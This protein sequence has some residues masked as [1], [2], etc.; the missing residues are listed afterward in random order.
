MIPILATLAPLAQAGGVRGGRGSLTEFFLWLGLAI[1]AIVAAGLAI[2][3]YRSR[4][5]RGDGAS[6]QAGLMDDLRAMRDRG[7]LSVEEFDAAKRA[8]VARFS[9][10]APVAP[11][12][13]APPGKVLKRAVSPPEAGG[14]VAKPGFDLTGAPLPRPP[15]DHPRGAR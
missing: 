4:V 2:A 5:L 11:A 6:V 9:G 7:E 1:V 13:G 15:G 8:I 12:A 3:W 14:A 10:G